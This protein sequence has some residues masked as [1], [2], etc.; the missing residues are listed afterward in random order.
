MAFWKNKNNHFILFEKETP[1]V[2]VVICAR[3]EAE[4]LQKY[5][6][7]LL[8]QN[9]PNFEVIVIDD[10]SE[11]ATWTI[12]K[13]F[14]NT[15][16]KILRIYHLENKT[17]L[18]KKAALSF[19]ITQAKNEWLLLTDADCTPLSNNWI[20]GMTE[21]R[22]NAATDIVL[23]Y[24]PYR[25]ENSI[26]NDFI[27]FETVLTA[28]QYLSFALVGEPYMGVGRN[29]LYRK[30]LF[31]EAG[32]FERHRDLASGDDDLFINQV[33]T[34]LN[35]RITINPQTFM[36]SDAKNTWS[37][38]IRQKKRHLSAGVRYR[39]RHKLWLGLIANTHFLGYV[40]GFFLI[41][42]NYSTIFV[43][44]FLGIKIA[45]TWFVYGK[46]VKK[47]Q[48]KRLFYKIFV[49]DLAFLLF[50]TLLVPLLL[51]SNKKQPIWK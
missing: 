6:P 24:A 26:L 20:S 29:M 15:H 2:S 48:E 35:T 50:Y 22:H 5:L 49:F 36:V 11:D 28:I 21:G 1:S 23:G 8:N 30:R 16:K 38:Y 9:Y 32:G 13:D 45:A 51:L 44:T 19:G 40:L 43:I 3:N 42:L 4:N 31:F 27:R 34:A 46:I 12:L 10:A 17:S 47:L 37:A 33:A 14:E 18:G 25:A 41:A 39:L 7:N